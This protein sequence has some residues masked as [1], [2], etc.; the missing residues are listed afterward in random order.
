MPSTLARPIGHEDRLSLV[1][2]LDELRSRLIVCGSV[3]LI[4]FVVCAWQNEALLGVLNDPL[5]RA[6]E[7]SIKKG[8]GL[9]GQLEKTQQAVR[10]IGKQQTVLGEALVDPGLD[11]PA[12]TRK[13]L[14]QGN[15]AVAQAI[16]DLP[17]TK[18]NQPV[19]LRVGEPFMTTLTVALYFSLLFAMPLILYQLYAFVLPAFRPEEKRVALP[20]MAMVPFLFIGGVVFGY[21]VVLP[22]AT[23]FLQNFNSD[24][25]NVLVQAQDYYKFAVLA[26]AGLGILFQLPVAILAATRI[27]LVTPLQLRQNRRYSLLI[28]AVVA[29]LLPGTDPVTML[30]SMTPLLV[31]YEASIWLAVLF[32]RGRPQANVL[33]RWRDEWGEDEDE[34]D[35]EAWAGVDEEEFLEDDEAVASAGDE[36]DGGSGV[37]RA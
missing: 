14:Q 4:A 16:R 21:F 9:P 8:Y 36:S 30:I 20:L 24:S 32:N 18:G 13:A 7:T 11:L 25:F 33:S 2:H 28:I 34:E 3:L 1:E 6:T 35:P 23:Q 27:G 19:T 26:L 29:M 22:P 37:T 10:A 12:A 17:R 5:Q 31:L 15:A